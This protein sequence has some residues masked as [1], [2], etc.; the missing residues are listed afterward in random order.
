MLESARLKLDRAK[1]HIGDL[2]AAFD[3]FVQTHSH[4]LAVGSDPN[5]GE[6]T[7]ELRFNEQIP[8]NISLIL[9]DAVH[10][11]RTALDHAMWEL[12]GLDGGTQ[13]KHTTLP[14]GDTR[15]NYESRCNG[16]KTPRGD[17]KKFLV[18]LATYK[19]GAGGEIYAMHQLDNREKHTIITPLASLVRISRMKFVDPH[20]RVIADMADS[21]FGPGPDGRVRVARMGPGITVEF[22]QNAERTIEIF[23]RDVEGFRFKRIVP[24]L[25]HLADAVS[26]CLGQF[27]TFVRTRK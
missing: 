11:L 8:T 27:E 21:S 25:M 3:A 6:I 18:G 12:M 5:T 14:T 23:F 17:T 2:K 22:D 7:V 26:D 15:Q 13:D 9:A 19:G 1:H 10:N 20:G 4:T 24:T 16:I